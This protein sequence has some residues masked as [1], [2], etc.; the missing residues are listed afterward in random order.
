MGNEEFIDR[1][2]RAAAGDDPGNQ[3]DSLVKE[4]TKRPPLYKVILHNDDYTTQEWVV[5][6]LKSFFQ[7]N[8]AEAVQL[9]LH[10]H[11]NGRAI[12]GVFP[13]DIAETKVD[14]VTKASQDAGYPLLCSYEIE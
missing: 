7:K 6:I 9:M 12:V 3:G 5:L 11:H 8:H 13:R 14:Q 4:K 2:I 1:M 10:V